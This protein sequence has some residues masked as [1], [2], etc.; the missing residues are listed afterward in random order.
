[1]RFDE[2]KVLGGRRLPAHMVLTP[3]DVEGQRTEM[4]YLELQ[5]DVPVPDD[6]FSLSRLERSR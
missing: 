6:T 5:F 4:R 3:A 2:V 1:M